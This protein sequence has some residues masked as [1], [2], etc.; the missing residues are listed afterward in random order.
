MLSICDSQHP[1]L[2]SVKDYFVRG[3]SETLPGQ[4][5][6]IP[7]CASGSLQ[8]HLL[9]D[10][11]GLKSWE[12]RLKIARGL[13]AGLV[14]LHSKHIFH[15]DIKPDN[16]LLS[17]KLETQL[18]D[19]G[20]SKAVE[21]GGSAMATSYKT[22]HHVGTA[23]YA[24]PEV[25]FG[26]FGPKTDVYAAGVVLL[27]LATGKPAVVLDKRGAPTRLRDHLLAQHQV[28]TAGAVADS[29]PGAAFSAF[30]QAQ[31][32][33]RCTWPPRTVAGLLQLGLRCTE[34]EAHARPPAVEVEKVLGDLLKSDGGASAFGARPDMLASEAALTCTLCE[35]ALR[36]CVLLPCNHAVGCGPCTAKL[37]RCPLC[38]AVKEGVRPPDGPVLQTWQG[39]AGGGCGWVPLQ[40]SNN[41]PSMD[42]AALAE[43]MALKAEK[44]KREA[45]EKERRRQKEAEEARQRAEA[46]E[47]RRR[48][49]A[50]AARIEGERR[51]RND[52]AF[53]AAWWAAEHETAV[54][55][56]ASGAAPL[57]WVFP[58]D[59]YDVTVAPGQP[60]Q[61][62]VDACPAGGCVLLLPGTHVGPLVLTAGKEVHVFGRGL[63][64]LRAA[65][66]V[67][68][69][70]AAVATLDG[71]IIW[72]DSGGAGHGVWIKGGA[73][74]LQTCNISSAAPGR[75]Y[76][77]FVT[78]GDPLLSNSRRAGTYFGNI[79]GRAFMPRI[80]GVISAIALAARYPR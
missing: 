46:E 16:V 31:A 18:A 29:D 12:D 23:G 66:T 43:L 2:L 11:S 76:C 74:L 71:L 53:I 26:K 39:P 59:A 45:E 50:E 10:G 61:A 40:A 65:G 27:Q 25:Q 19:F 21:A 41:A 33:P 67:V 36:D 58:P 73:L 79:A 20:V 64:T 80:G 47:K 62:A 3:P 60:V 22:V 44:R 15:R 48:K 8:V 75:V 69:S 28:T 52:P 68:T 1:N 14:H 17:S 55:A 4:Y 54:V 24:A 30:A 56:R 38:R 51:Q 72:R 37:D 42:E 5:L 34:T 63:A 13:A 78:G 49:E 77:V 7:Y 32:D 9:G 6:V 70:E 57:G 35:E